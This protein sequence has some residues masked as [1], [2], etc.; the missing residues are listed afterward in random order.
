MPNNFAHRLLSRG[1]SSAIVV[2]ASHQATFT[3]EPQRI[4]KTE[5]SV[6]YVSTPHV[7]CKST[8]PGVDP[9]LAVALH[10]SARLCPSCGP[11]HHRGTV[12]VVR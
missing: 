1:Q 10:M 8:F 5:E 12:G 6:G 2:Q 4:P 7:A 9:A 3:R 11:G